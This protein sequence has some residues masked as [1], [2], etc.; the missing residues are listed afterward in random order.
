MVTLKKISPNMLEL[1]AKERRSVEAKA[2][3]NTLRSR[4]RRRG[5]GEKSEEKFSAPPPL[6]PSLRF[7][8]WALL[9]A[10]ART[11]LVYGPHTPE[12]LK[13]RKCRPGTGD[14]PK[15]AL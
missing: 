4:S 6:P 12:Y 8:P 13:Q 11:I 9:L 3:A 2:A 1:I 7:W 15:T 10:R 5:G 14:D